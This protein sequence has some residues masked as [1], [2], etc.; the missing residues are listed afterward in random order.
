MDDKELL[1][2]ENLEIWYGK[3]HALSV[4][5]LY[6][7]KGRTLIIGPNASGKTSLIKAA[8]G[9]IMPKRGKILVM[10][11]DPIREASQLYEKV[12]YVPDNNP[13]PPGIKLSTLVR[14]LSETYGKERV[15]EVVEKLG[16]MDYLGKRLGDLSKGTAR[17]ASLLSALVTSKDLVI[18][19][20]PFSGLDGKARNIVSGILGSRESSLIVI[21]HIPLRIYFD[22]LII[23]E[24]GKVSY[25]GEYRDPKELGY[26]LYT[27]T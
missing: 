7:P 13:Y 3:V 4:D 15:Y 22:Y 19:D 14:L 27:W 24:A 11:L 23:I 8:L 5:K 25:I 18:I 12:A 6:L 1:A 26:D 16:L 20:E 2:V 17:K 21:S 10:G 9:L